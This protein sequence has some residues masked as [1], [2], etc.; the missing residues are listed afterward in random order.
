M[1][2]A[3]AGMGPAGAYLSALLSDEYRVEIYEMQDEESFTSVCAWGTGYHKMREMLKRVGLNFDDYV[4]FRGKRLYVELRERLFTVRL[5]GLS[6]FDKPRLLKDLVSKVSVNYGK[7]VR[8]GELETKYYRVIDA[9]GVYRR[10]L[11]NIEDDLLMP[12]IQ[13]LVKFKRPPFDD[14]Y[15]KPFKSYTGYLWYFPLDN[16][17]FFVGAGDAKYNKHIETALRFIR[18][19]DGEIMKRMGKALRLT[20]PTKALP[21]YFMNTIGVGEAVGS[22]F[23]VLGEGILPSMMSA[24]LLYENFEDPL[25]YSRLLKRKF[26]VFEYALKFLMAK[27]NDKCSIK[28]CLIPALKLH[29]YFK[30]NKDHTGVDPSLLDTLKVL[31]PF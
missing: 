19:H 8:P 12:T 3:I 6:T 21:H 18:E 29:L 9:T 26:K 10:L 16:G 4:I 30:R 2:V 23:A 7:A 13:Y 1:K 15:V 5:A 14:F 17:R 24:E 11:P 20:P 28:E 22:V 27:M 25:G 31:K